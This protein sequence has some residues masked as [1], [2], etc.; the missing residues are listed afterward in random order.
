[1]KRFFVLLLLAASGAAQASLAWAGADA[2]TSGFGVHAGLALLPVPF[3]GTLGVEAS[4]ER[5]WNDQS[6]SRL[7]AGL[8][9]RDLNLPLTRV[10]AFAT[11][12]GEY[13][14][15]TAAQS[16]QLLGYAEA[17]LRGPLL[18][19]AGWRAFARANT[20]GHFGAGLGLE[21]RF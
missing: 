12:G 11:L 20:A 21:L 4:G 2:T 5:G 15:T 17:G 18:G 19:P 6:P 8:T 10:D 14:T 3:L 13:R 9:L 7:A 1:M 16:S